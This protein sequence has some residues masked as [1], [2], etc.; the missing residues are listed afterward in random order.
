[1]LR[2]PPEVPSRERVLWLGLEPGEH[3][4]LLS[5]VRRRLGLD[6]AEAA[7]IAE[8]SVRYLRELE[9]GRKSMYQER[10]EAVLKVY[11]DYEVKGE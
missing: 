1:M 9:M 10:F 5:L 11:H 2:P 8:I 4:V 6:R 7:R 3:A